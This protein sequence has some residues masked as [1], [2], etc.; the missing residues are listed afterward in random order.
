M[1]AA[2]ALHSLLT[3]DGLGSEGFSGVASFSRSSGH[4]A[5]LGKH[6]MFQTE[7]LA[8]RPRCAVALA[9]NFIVA[10]RP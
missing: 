10:V 3:A 7:K 9:E 6:L 8:T 1:A 5:G 2:K 4:R